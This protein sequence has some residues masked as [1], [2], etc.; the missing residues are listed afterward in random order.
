MRSFVDKECDCDIKCV[1]LMFLYQDE[2]FWE[3]SFWIGMLSKF[4][5]GIMRLKIFV[6]FNYIMYYWF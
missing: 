5:N 6:F 3:R 2:I 4:L 1:D